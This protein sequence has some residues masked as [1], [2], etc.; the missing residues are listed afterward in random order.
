MAEN[1]PP[2]PIASALALGI[3]ASSTAP[4]LLID[5]GMTVLVASAS[6]YATFDIRPGTA[7]GR[8]FFKLGDGEWATPQLRV[9]LRATLA[10]SADIDAYEF[11]LRRHGEA[12]RQ[13]VLNAKR[14]DSEDG[15]SLLLTLSD[16]TDARIADRLKDELLREKAILLHEI[17]H[18]VANSL[19]IIASVL[20]QSARHVQSEETRVH[21]GDAHRRVM[22][23][24]AARQQF[25]GTRLDEVELRA[26]FEE[27]CESLGASMIRD[28]EQQSI[29]VNA[30][31]SRV[32]ADVSVS[33]GLIVTE[34][35]INALKHAFPAGAPGRITVDYHSRGPNW[36][37]CVG[38]N[39]AGMPK[40][41]KDIRQGLGT[42]IVDALARQLHAHVHVADSRP[43]TAV[44][45]V[46]NQ[47]AAVGAAA[48]AV[49]V[50]GGAPV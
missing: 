45:I 40:D 9:L 25:A 48:E 38:D 41:P 39:G 14:L 18:R 6:F 22:S 34:L 29:T 1:A 23:I 50:A 21:L 33:L 31:N 44:S 24:A 8:G 10:G 43:G 2:S 49:S 32:E 46:H 37:L 36:V 28:H 11:E 20:L 42:S 12:N 3:I 15:V 35:V 17:H 26:Y 30:D 5:S 27:L 13:I 4:L 19:Q 16:V 7:V 47:I